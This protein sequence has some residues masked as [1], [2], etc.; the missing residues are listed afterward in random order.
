MVHSFLMIG[1]SNMAGRGLIGEEPPIENANLFML[2]NGRWYPLSEPVNYDRPFAGVSLAVSFADEYQKKFGGQ[3]GLIPCADGGT[4][5]EDWR[6]GGQ[7]YTHAVYQCG[8]AK[9]ISEVK[10]V[11]WHQGEGDSG[12]EKNASSYAKRFSGMIKALL[13]DC[14]V[15]GAPVILGELGYFLKD[16]PKNAEPFFPVVNRELAKL[17]AE[18]RGMALAGAEGLVS[19]GDNL[20]FDSKSLREFG[21]RY[22]QKYLELTGSAKTG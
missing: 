16:N 17:A 18:N 4:S 3:A 14:G 12:D 21:R 2:R 19:K 7:L 10:G 11:L 13:R 15:E 22:F 20:H 8:L 5:L 9:N 1:Q 6:E